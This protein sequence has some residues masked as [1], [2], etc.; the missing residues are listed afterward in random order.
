VKKWLLQN[1]PQEVAGFLPP[2]QSLLETTL[3]LVVTRALQA[4]TTEPP[5]GIVLG[6]THIH[7]TRLARLVQPVGGRSTTRGLI[8]QEVGTPPPPC[9]PHTMLNVKRVKDNMRLAFIEKLFTNREIGTSVQTR[10]LRFKGMLYENE[11]YLC[12][13]NCVQLQKA[14]AWFQCGNTQLEA[15]QGVW[16]GVPYVERLC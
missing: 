9:F 15:V 14:L 5:L 6:S 1:Q 7:P 2:A 3:Q 8:N 11:R 10:Y 13:I 4:R 12:D 16:L